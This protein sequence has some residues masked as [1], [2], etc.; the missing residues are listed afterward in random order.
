[1]SNLSLVPIASRIARAF[2]REDGWRGAACG[3][4]VAGTG[5]GGGGWVGGAGG[6]FQGIG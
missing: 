5:S 6:V 2:G 3:L 1:V 4:L